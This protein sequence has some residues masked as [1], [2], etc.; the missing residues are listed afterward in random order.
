MLLVQIHVYQKIR[1]WVLYASKAWLKISACNA[2]L[3][4]YNLSLL[5]IRESQNLWTFVVSQVRNIAFPLFRTAVFLSNMA[6]VASWLA[7]MF[8]HKMQP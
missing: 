6:A 5:Q 8:G 2:I 7:Q 4:D 3:K 1:D